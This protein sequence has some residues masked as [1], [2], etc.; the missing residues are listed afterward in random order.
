MSESGSWLADRV[1]SAAEAAPTGLQQQASPD[2]VGRPGGQDGGADWL[3]NKIAAAGAAPRW[4]SGGQLGSTENGWNTPFYQQ[5]FEQQT[6]EQERG[7]LHNLYARQD[8]TGIAT[9]DQ[10]VGGRDVKYGD[11]W[12]NGRKVGNVYEQ[13]DVVTADKMLA[14]LTLDADTQRRVYSES[15]RNPAAIHTAL[16]DRRARTNADV[17]NWATSQDYADAVEQTEAQIE[18]GLGTG[19]SGTD[20]AVGIGGAALAA[21]ATGAG[22]GALAGPVGA[23]IGGVVG[24]VAGGLGAWMNQDELTE[25]AARVQEQTELAQRDFG[26]P[27]A[28]ATGVAGWSGLA[29]KA[30]TPLTNILHGAYELS[31]DGRAAIGDGDAEWYTDVDPVTGESNRSGWWT[32]AQ[33]GTGVAD[34][35]TQ[36]ASPIGQALFLGTMTGVVG[37]QVAQLPLTGGQT[38]DDRRGAFDNIFTDDQGNPDMGSAAAGILN[39]GIDAVQLG[40]GRGLI[41]TADDAAIAAGTQSPGRIRQLVERLRGGRTTEVAGGYAFT[42]GADGAITGARP[43]VA[44][45]A[46][47]EALQAVSARVLAQRAALKDGREAA[48]ADDLYRATQSL[49]NGSTPVKQ[50]LVT[51]FGEGG[52]EAAQAVLEPWSHGASPDGED[53][54]ESFLQGAAMGAGMSIGVNLRSPSSDDRIR[55]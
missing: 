8:Y 39:I 28:I 21:G 27:A 31:T 5:M 47:S 20:E 15:A 41:R 17:K 49:S 35:L 34:A 26:T 16:E 55:A 32:A 7:N 45:L 22:V 10:T 40:M 43:S 53:V 29:L 14:Q 13:Y 46:P 19:W 38:F 33:L 18:G 2:A 48:T 6:Q 3:A 11:V 37:G 36:F 50:A 9:W 51:A 12:E 24:A 1:A 4:E 42:R 30:S 54:F 44:M 52:E 23:A 25:Q